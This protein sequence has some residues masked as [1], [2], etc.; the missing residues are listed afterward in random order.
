LKKVSQSRRYFLKTL[1]V[2]IGSI[3]L[4]IW[5][6]LV[7]TQ[8]RNATKKSVT[9]S[10]IDHK[11]VIFNEECIIVIQE[12]LQVFSEYC[13]H[14]GCRI[15]TYEKGQLICPCHGSVF[16]L[17]GNPLKGPAVKPLDKLPFELN[18]DTNTIIVNV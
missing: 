14:L 3:S 17:D 6:A 9:I 18:N 8:K 4:G 13:S 15:Q 16:D 11:E 10:L 1:G 5:G 7:K 12:D 2:V